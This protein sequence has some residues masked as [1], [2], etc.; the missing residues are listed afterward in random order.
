MKRVLAILMALLLCVAMLPAAALAETKTVY[1]NSSGSGTLNLRGGPGKDYEP[2]GTVKHGAKVSVKKTSGEW[3]KVTVSS[4]GKTGWIKTKYIDGTTKSLGTGTKTVKTSSGSITL[5]S[6]PGSSYGSKGSVKNGAKVKVLETENNWVKISLVS[7]GKTGWIPEK[8]IK[9]SSSGGSGGESSGDKLKVRSVSNS[10]LNVRS[11]PGTSYS[12]LN[13]LYEGEAM[14]VLET[15]GGWY[16]IQT[17]DGVKGWVAGNLTSA[18]AKAKVTSSTLN[19]RKSANA[20]SAK[21]G[22]MVKGNVVKVDY[23]IGNW[24]HA[25]FGSKTGF[26]SLSYLSF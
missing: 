17:F 1:V 2:V 20:S 18:G 5:R 8:N 15:S 4:T 12:K 21:V 26:A 11:G 7:S 23:V 3:S 6:G 22:Q 25:T 16:R 14:K 24:A 13:T 19:L 10:V 9:G